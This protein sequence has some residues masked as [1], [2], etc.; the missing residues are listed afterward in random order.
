MVRRQPRATLFPHPSVFRPVVVVSSAAVLITAVCWPTGSLSGGAK[1]PEF[2]AIANWINSRP[3]T[4]EELRGRV[5]LIDFWTYTCVN[6]IR[7]MPYLKD[8]H[9]KYASHGLV[10]VG[11]HS[12]EFE[13]EKLAENVADDA[14]ELGLAY[15]IAQDNDLQ[16]WRRTE[17]RRVGQ[18]C[19]YRGVPDH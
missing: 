12:P 3:L 14:R 7:T 1:A 18:G 5:V 6:C 17:G 4:M 9:A 16:T 11:V 15:A 8:W 10:I 19:R 2:Q 13:F